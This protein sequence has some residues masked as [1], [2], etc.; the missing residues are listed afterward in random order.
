MKYTSKLILN[1]TE[2]AFTDD[3]TQVNWIHKVMLNGNTYNIKEYQEWWWQPWANTIGYRPLEEDLNDYSWNSNNFTLKTWSISYWTASWGWKYAYFN[4]STWTN[5]LLLSF[6][7]TKSFTLSFYF[8]PQQNY[9]ANNHVIV[10]VWWQSNTWVSMRTAFYNSAV[11]IYERIIHEHTISS[12]AMTLNTWYYITI[13]SDTTNVN[14]YVNWTFVVS[15]VIN[16]SAKT[17]WTSRVSISQVWD[18]NSS[19]F[20]SEMYIARLIYEKEKWWSADEISAY[21]NSTKSLYWIS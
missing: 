6:D 18:T 9:T 7:F 3:N 8:N 2:Y 14:L 20:A 11:N 12:N 1:W 17:S 16:N 10:D 19:N 15:N 13:V 21:F 4:G 5:Y